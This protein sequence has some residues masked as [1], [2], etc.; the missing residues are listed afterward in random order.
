MGD[1]VTAD[2]LMRVFSKTAEPVWSMIG[3]WLKGGM[4][5]RDPS[6][7]RSNYKDGSLDDE[8][9][10]E[11][12]ELSLLDPDFW[13]D[14]YV[15]RESAEDN[16]SKIVPVFLAHVVEHVLESGKAVGLLRAM[17]IQ[18]LSSDDRVWLSEWRSFTT[19][20]EVEAHREASSHPIKSGD[21]SDAL[22]SV[23]TDTLSR[24]VYD[25]L[26]PHCQTISERLTNVLVDECL[27][28][29]HLFAIEDLF[30][31][32]RGDAMGHFADVLFAKVRPFLLFSLPF[33][34]KSL[35]GCGSSLE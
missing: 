10:I 4:S 11:D 24:I 15:L 18:P 21:H 32:R 1:T 27:L 12:N 13:R 5:V 19:L 9:F 8:F 23:S 3:R 31:L 16:G 22:F 25:E 26:L 7:L 29:K 28:W 20:L 14:G 17:D 35:D 2:M 34:E 33:S 6:G 30:L